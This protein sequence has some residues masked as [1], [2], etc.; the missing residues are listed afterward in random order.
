MSYQVAE[1]DGAS[2]VYLAGDVDL[3]KSPQARAVLL[4]CVDRKK[5]LVVDLEGVTYIDSSGIASLVEAFQAA[6]K[7]DITFALRNVSVAAKK[8]IE[9][10]RLEKVF[11]ILS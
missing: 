8:E 11:T 4:E 1:Q 2:V 3:E 9:L 6:R 5:D 10:A 7:I